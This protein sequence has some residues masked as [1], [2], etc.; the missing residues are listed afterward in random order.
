M[1]TEILGFI[2][3]AGALVYILLRR[4]GM[5]L[6][7]DSTG[8]EA[9]EVTAEK[10]R[11]EMEKSADEIIDRLAE[12]IDRLESLIAQAEEVSAKLDGRLTRLRKEIHAAQ[13]SGILPVMTAEQLK[14]AAQNQSGG[15]SAPVSSTTY[16]ATGQ[17]AKQMAAAEAELAEATEFSRLLD[18]TIEATEAAALE[19]NSLPEQNRV[20]EPEPAAEQ[21]AGQ[22]KP[23]R[24]DYYARAKELKEQMPAYPEEGIEAVKPVEGA[25]LA[26]AARVSAVVAL[27]PTEEARRLLAAGYATD[28]I[29]RKVHLGKGAIE[30]LRQM[31]GQK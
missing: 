29:A 22:T 31:D 20:V 10:I 23:K 2:I 28:D 13:E 15:Q 9:A 7:G 25:A 16:G 27:S 11:F 6:F 3:V 5:T 21:E 19:I 26:A 4:R 8:L 18:S 17:A 14:T 30:L 24:I 1:V 12:H